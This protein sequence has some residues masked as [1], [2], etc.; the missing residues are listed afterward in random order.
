MLQG[1]C[2]NDDRDVGCAVDFEDAG[3]FIHGSAAGHHVI[4]QQYLSPAQVSAAFK[5]AP[6]V[7]VTLLEGQI[8]LSRR[9][10]VT[11]KTAAVNR[12]IEAISNDLG[13]FRRL[14]ETAFA[15][16]I[17][18]QG[19]RDDEL[20]L[21]ND[22]LGQ[23]ATQPAGDGQ[24][25]TVFE[26]VNDTVNREIITKSGKRSIEVW[27]ILQAGATAFAMRRLDTALQAAG[28]R[29][30][31]EVGRAVRAEQA[32]LAIGATEQAAFR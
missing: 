9:R 31:R 26:R 24:L 22:P 29:E 12:Q 21:S 20:V 8:G 1:A 19:Q 7:F 25:M 28:G 17:R 14:I 27:C 32:I 10:P 6:D 15:Q 23:T 18:V 30:R 11:K 4:D 5:S 16:A 2:R 13:N 3:A